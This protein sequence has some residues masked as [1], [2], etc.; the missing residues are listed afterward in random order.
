MPGSGPRNLKG[1]RPPLEDK[2][3]V[4]SRAAGFCGIP[5]R[6]TQPALFG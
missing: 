6:V 3:I 1:L 2:R 5:P 4:I